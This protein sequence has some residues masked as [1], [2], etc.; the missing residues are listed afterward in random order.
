MKVCSKCKI[1][2]DY[3]EFHKDKSRKD[4][5]RDLCKE[6][7]SLYH[8]GYY[9]DNKEKIFEYSKKYRS[10]N[11]EKIRL[12]KKLYGI[13]NK[14]KISKRD[15]IYRKNNLEKITE[16]EK[17]YRKN[18]KEKIA[19]KDKLYYQKNKETIAFSYKKYYSKNRKHIIGRQIA[20][21][22]I[23]YKNDINYKLSVRIRKRMYGAI[24]GNQKAGSAVSDLGCSV[25][26]LKQ[27]LESKFQPGMSWENYGL[28]GW[29]IDHII[30]LA[31]FDLTDREQFLKACHYTNLQPLWAVDNLR[32]SDK[33]L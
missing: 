1:E 13:N 4:G 3:L 30:P 5:H 6:C 12:S 28:Y 23:R 19:L 10:E 20:N 24:I 29:H 14:E 32:K 33:I 15:K 25:E 9:S 18:N 22:K 2:K 21:E 16:Y 31:S 27:Y 17:L 11:K 8:K 26:F 7:K